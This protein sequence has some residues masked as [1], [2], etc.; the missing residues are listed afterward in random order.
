MIVAIA[1]DDL[2][3]SLDTLLDAGEHAWH[4]GQVT[5]GEGPVEFL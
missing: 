3:A 4:I 5:D 2:A 1:A